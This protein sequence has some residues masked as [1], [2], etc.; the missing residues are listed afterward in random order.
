MQA[1]QIAVV[2]AL[3]ASIPMVVVLVTGAVLGR[4]AEAAITAGAMFGTAFLVMAVA[5]TRLIVGAYRAS[6]SSGLAL[7]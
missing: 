3:A 7:R 5:S 4:P 6:V 1:I 2:S